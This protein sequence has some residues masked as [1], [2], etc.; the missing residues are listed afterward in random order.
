[1]IQENELIDALATAVD[2]ATG[3]A[4]PN[5]NVHIQERGGAAFKPGASGSPR[6]E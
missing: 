5:G 3:K 6:R 2:A 4:D 1:M